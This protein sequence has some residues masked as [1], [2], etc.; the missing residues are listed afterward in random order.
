MSSKGFK[1]Y[2]DNSQTTGKAW[3]PTVTTPTKHQNKVLVK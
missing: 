3:A 1:R 2:G